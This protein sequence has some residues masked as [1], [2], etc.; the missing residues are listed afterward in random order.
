MQYG[1]RLR[2]PAGV[3]RCTRCIPATAF[4]RFS[5][6][7]VHLLVLVFL[8]S[9]ALSLSFPDIPFATSFEYLAY[10]ALLIR[11]I[12]RSPLLV[13]VLGAYGIHS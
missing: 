8:F 4:V 5:F 12:A 11:D 6:S 1:A 7:L 10:R 2:S 13:R 3:T 9:V